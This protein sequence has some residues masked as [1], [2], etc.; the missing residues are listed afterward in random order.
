MNHSN[1]ESS[2]SYAANYSVISAFV[3]LWNSINPT[4]INIKYPIQ[5]LTVQFLSFNKISQSRYHQ[6]LQ[7][8]VVAQID[9]WIS[10][11]NCLRA[12]FVSLNYCLWPIE[13]QSVSLTSSLSFA[14]FR[15][16]LS[17]F[18]CAFLLKET[19]VHLVC[20]SHDQMT[21]QLH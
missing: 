4:Q 18:F 2:N 9:H 5:K 3:C 11:S 15:A 6:P 13:P 7:W 10:S 19:F 21:I 17:L 1:L 14:C 12:H 20:I 16:K 8:Y